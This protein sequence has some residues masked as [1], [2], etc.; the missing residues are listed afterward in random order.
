MAKDYAGVFTSD[1]RTSTGLTPTFILFYII[2]NGQTLTPPG[3]TET[4]AGSGAYYFSYGPTLAIYF[5]ID[6]GSGLAASERYL[7]GVLD[8][9]QVV[10]Q[11]IGTI[12]DTFGTTMSDPTTLFGY[13]KRA[14]E[15]WEGNAIFTKASGLWRI[16]SRGSSTLLREKNLTNN[17]TSA[18]K[19]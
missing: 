2:A 8:P 7:T 18:E 5:Q 14:L 6:G 3:I 4:F 16:F 17:T 12:D 15:F 11:R 9:L 19:D 13:A 10:D 1:P